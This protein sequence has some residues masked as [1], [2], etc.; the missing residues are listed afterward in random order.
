[1]SGLNERGGLTVSLAMPDNLGRFA[2]GLDLVLFR[3]I[4]ECLTNV[5]RHSSSRTATIRIDVRDG[6]IHLDVAD[7]GRGIAPQ[8]LREIQREGSG[9][10]MQG[11]RERIRPF[12]GEMNVLSTAEGTTVKFTF[13]VPEGEPEADALASGVL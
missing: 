1:V 8:K 2:R 13:P 9:V 5:Y 12:N 4:Q 7:D 11:M 3:L 6:R 10:G